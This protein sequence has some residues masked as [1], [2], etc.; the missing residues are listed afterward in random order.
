MNADERRYVYAERKKEK[1]YQ[2]QIDGD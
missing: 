1:I 2:P